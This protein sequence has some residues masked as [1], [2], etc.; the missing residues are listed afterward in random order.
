MKNDDIIKHEGIITSI[1]EGK[2][3]VK[4]LSKSAC[5]ECHAKGAC[6]MSDLQEKI[7]EVENTRNLELHEGQKVNV[8]MLTSMGIKAVIA[9][10]LIPFLILMA[11]LFT[12][13]GLT[14]KEGLA[15]LLGLAAMIPYYIILS[16]LKPGLKK[17]F[18]FELEPFDE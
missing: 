8:T 14:K 5:A 7:I 4:I 6:G 15:A 2:P 18:Y 1:T 9:G 3:M 17:K 11:V 16:K 13:L 10:Y 12:V